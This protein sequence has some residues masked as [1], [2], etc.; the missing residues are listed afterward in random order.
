MIICYN[1]NTCTYCKRSAIKLIDCNQSLKVL[2]NKIVSYKTLLLELAKPTFTKLCKRMTESKFNSSI[3]PH[4][5]YQ[6]IIQNKEYC[7]PYKV[8]S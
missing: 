5:E 4:I 6:S 1:Y 3:I 8:N 2:E 7:Y